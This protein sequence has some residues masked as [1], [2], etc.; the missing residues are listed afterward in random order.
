MYGTQYKYLN[1]YCIL[2]VYLI[3]AL[4]LSQLLLNRNEDMHCSIGILAMNKNTQS[5]Y[6]SKIPL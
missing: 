1:L 3:T 4:I 2:A 5:N 6:C